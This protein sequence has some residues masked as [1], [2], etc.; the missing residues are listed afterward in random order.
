MSKLYTI[1]NTG[2]Q[3]LSNSAKSE[4]SG[5]RVLEYISKH[6]RVTPESI[7]QNTGLKRNDIS[8]ILGQ[9]S[10]NKLIREDIK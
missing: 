2:S 8:Y 4:L 7:E 3:I 10:R 5:Y 9:L 6:D 1:T